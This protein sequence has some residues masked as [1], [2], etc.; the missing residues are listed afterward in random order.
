MAD[1]QFNEEQ[2]FSRRTAAAQTPRFVRL[3]LKT[4]IVST[5]KG[6]NYV[7]LIAVVV[8]GILALFVIPFSLGPTSSK[9]IINPN[10]PISPPMLNT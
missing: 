7:L 5:E 1:I 10:I 4:G 8:A 2:E 9:P 6:A 3:V